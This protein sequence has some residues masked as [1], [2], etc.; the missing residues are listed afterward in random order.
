MTNAEDVHSEKT[1]QDGLE[2]LK[3]EIEKL[4]SMLNSGGKPGNS[5]SLTQSGKYSNSYALSASFPAQNSTWI[6]D[7]G[8]TDHMVFSHKPF[9]S[10]KPCPSNKK[11]RIADGNCTIVAGQGTIPPP[12]LC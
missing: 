12:K 7:S 2:T 10:Y 11:N 1:N 4:K 6:M 3:E 5:C 9:S 8:A